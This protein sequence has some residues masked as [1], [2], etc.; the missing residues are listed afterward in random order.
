MFSSFKPDNKFWI[1]VIAIILAVTLGIITSV[2]FIVVDRDSYSSIYLVPDSIL[3]T[4]GDTILLF[5]YGV[6]SSEM[7]KMDYTLDTYL[8]GENINNKQFS[9]NPGEILEERQEITLP[10]G[11]QYPSKIS[12][13][14]TTKS[15]SEEVHFWLK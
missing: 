5:E 12:L 8:N 15:L 10:P 13:K 9:L 2:F 14:L 1:F 3:H 11:T 4:H 6:K 7:G